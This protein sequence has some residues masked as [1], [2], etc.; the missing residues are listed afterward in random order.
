MIKIFS[1]NLGALHGTLNGKELSTLMAPNRPKSLVL[2]ETE[3]P[4]YPLPLFPPIVKKEEHTE[5]TDATDDQSDNQTSSD[6]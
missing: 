1:G 5:S 3:V 4:N 6:N 2:P